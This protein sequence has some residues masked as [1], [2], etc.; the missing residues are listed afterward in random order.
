MIRII[1]HRP[2]RD[3]VS[4]TCGC[5]FGYDDED[6]DHDNDTGDDSINCPD[7]KR[8][9]LIVERWTHWREKNEM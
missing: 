5:I 2:S 8:K 9:I 3:V 7:C 4:C 1:R 6:I